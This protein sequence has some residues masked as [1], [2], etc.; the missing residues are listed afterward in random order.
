VKNLITPVFNLNSDPPISMAFQMMISNCREQGDGTFYR[1][2]IQAGK[3]HGSLYTHEG[4]NLDKG[5]Q[6][7]VI[8]PG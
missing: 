7:I 2:F 5:F 6:Y 8:K 3:V 4:M 1:R